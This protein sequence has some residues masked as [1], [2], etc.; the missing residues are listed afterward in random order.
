M[1]Q[2]DA[3]PAQKRQ[4]LRDNGYDVKERGRLSADAEAAYASQAPNPQAV[5]QGVPADQSLA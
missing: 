3:S 5:V 4:W 2:T 1:T